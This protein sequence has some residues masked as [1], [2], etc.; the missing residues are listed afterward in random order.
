M[1]SLLLASEG[2]K[3][4]ESIRQLFALVSV[5]EII[6][7]Y[8]LQVN[9][10]RIFI[11]TQSVEVNILALLTEADNRQFQLLVYACRG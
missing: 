1:E 7:N 4:P 5:T 10:A 6:N 3:V 8:S 11:E 9:S 2:G